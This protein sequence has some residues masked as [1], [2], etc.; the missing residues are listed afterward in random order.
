VACMVAGG[1]VERGTWKGAAAA[2]GCGERVCVFACRRYRGAMVSRAR[3]AYQYIAW[4]DQDLSSPV[5]C[6]PSTRGAVGLRHV[7]TSRCPS[8]LPSQER[9]R[10]ISLHLVSE[11][12]LGIPA[13]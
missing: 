1:D 12:E 13:G 3:Y 8:V 9:E 10:G 2:G 7:L 6:S 11:D 4:T 5:T